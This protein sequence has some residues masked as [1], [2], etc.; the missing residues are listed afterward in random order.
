M[1]SRRPTTAALLCAITSVP[2]PRWIKLVRQGSIFQA[3]DS[4]DGVDWEWLGTE[5]ITMAS[6]VY[7][8]LAVT[9]HNSSRLCGAEFEQVSVAFPP[10]SAPVTPRIGTGDGLLGVYSEDAAPA[11]P[12]LQRVDP[13]V[14]FDWGYGSPAENIGKNHFRVRWE[15]ELQAQS[16]QRWLA[17]P[18]GIGPRLGSR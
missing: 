3:F 12:L 9:S 18:L 10:P 11:E 17:G 13:D 6:R 4:A 2:S 1:S 14:N 5:R 7:V 15:G 8:G 16:A